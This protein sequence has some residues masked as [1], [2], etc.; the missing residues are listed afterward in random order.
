MIYGV[1]R[2]TLIWANVAAE[3]GVPIILQHNRDNQNYQ[4]FFETV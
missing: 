4:S 2:L 1:Q 3:L